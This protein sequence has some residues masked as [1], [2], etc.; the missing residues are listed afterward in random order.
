[1]TPKNPSEVFAGLTA[2]LVDE[3]D[4][5]DV[6]A[7]LLH[8][9]LDVLG[10]EAAGLLV[11]TSD[12]GFDILGSTSHRATELEIYQSQQHEGPCVDAVREARQVIAHGP[13][14]II[15]RW[16]EVGRMIV[17]AGFTAVHAVPMRWRGRSLGGINLFSR[18]ERTE[19]TA[20]QLTFA[21]SLADVA[22]LALLQPAPVDEMVSLVSSA[23]QGRVVVERAKGALSYTADLDME[24]AYHRLRA[25]A[26]QEGTTLTAAA[27]AVLD[28]ASSA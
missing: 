4:V 1:M 6:L 2:A 26:S 22:G 5:T 15:T 10:V 19:L 3:H 24:S 18:G 14:E 23:L 20:D 13:D 27:R 25:R 17:A 21:Q 28:E 7:S 12:G 16:P 8:D 11:R 9:C